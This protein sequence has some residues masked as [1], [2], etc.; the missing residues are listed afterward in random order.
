M[1]DESGLARHRTWRFHPDP[2]WQDFVST[3][4]VISSQPRSRRT[5]PEN[6]LKW[7]SVQPSEGG[8]QFEMADQFVSFGEA[9]NLEIHGHVLVWHQQTPDWVF[10]GSNGAPASR[11]QLLARL[12]AHMS[13]LSERYGS[14]IAYWDVVNE[15]LNDD[16]SLRDSPWRQ[17]IGEDYVEQAFAMAERQFPDA[18]LV[19][20]DYSLFL[21]N[22]TSAAICL[23]ASL[24]QARFASTPLG[25]RGTAI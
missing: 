23:A 24:K 7:N 8:F 1:P 5:Q 18:K 3:F 20:N 2:L 10:L 25:C 17:I 19:Y 16:G 15:A 6:V 12:E 21:P 4:K 22:K 11:Q 9:R 13:A 14:R